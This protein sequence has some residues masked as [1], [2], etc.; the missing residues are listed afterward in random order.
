MSSLIEK[1]LV[2]DINN[3]TT[4]LSK[5]NLDGLS[6][7]ELVK[8]YGIKQ[9]DMIIILGNSIPYIALLGAKAYKSGLSKD[10]MIVGGN[11]HSTKYLIQN[12]LRDN[13][14]K[15]INV[16]DKSEAEILSKI[17]ETIENI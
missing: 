6:H 12:V 10:I 17:I 1:Q 4:F 5:R 14:Y 8:Q 16:H 15:D 13:K 2:D 9:V 7:S 11:G 3:I